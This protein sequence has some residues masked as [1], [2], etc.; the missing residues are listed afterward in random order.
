[1]TGRIIFQP[2]RPTAGERGQCEGK[3][4]AESYRDGT[5]WECD[6]CGSR[7]E[8]WSGVKYNEPFSAW[9]RISEP[10]PNRT[11]GSDR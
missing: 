8:V 10:I 5:I 2:S 3:P 6:E 4:L 11:D 9:H 1:M 7:W